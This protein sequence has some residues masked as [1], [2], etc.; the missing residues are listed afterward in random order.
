MMDGHMSADYMDEQQ[1][2]NG[3][4]YQGAPYGAGA[5]LVPFSDGVYLG[6]SIMRYTI[7]SV[8]KN[9]VITGL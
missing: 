1:M 9:L 4:P 2:Y 7:L 6:F 8:G 5:R 3:N